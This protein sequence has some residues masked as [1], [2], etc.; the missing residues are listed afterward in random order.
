MKPLKHIFRRLALT[1]MFT[2]V[3]LVTLA[4]G[5][6]ANTAIFS[7]LN[8]VLIKP[9]PYPES[10]ALVGVWHAAPGIAS[11][12]GKKLECSPTM[13]FTYHEQNRAFQE[14]GLWSGG[15]ASV[16]GIDEPEQVEALFVT[17]GVLQALGVQPSL[18]RWFS[19][20]DDTPG[21]PETV[22]LTHGYWQRRFGGDASVIGRTLTI[23]FQ[24]RKVIGVMPQGFRSLNPNAELILPERFDRSKVFLGNFSYEGVARLKPGVTL[25]QANADIARMLQIWLESWPTPPG[26]DR[27]LF[28]NARLGPN[29]QLLKQDVVGDIGTV[30][31]VLMGTIGFVLLIAC[32]NVANLMLVRA[33][34]RQQEL[35]IRAALGAG[36][37]RIAREM[38]L[39]S[40]TLGVIGGVV[41]VALAYIGLRVL[42]AIGPATLPRLSEIEIDPLVLLFTLAVS[43]LAGVLFGLIPVLKYAGPHLA[44]ALRG[45]G[46][47]L[48]HSR[49]RHRARNTLVV[50][51]VALALMLLIGAGLMIRTFQALRST[52]P[53]FARPD[54][55]QMLRISI[56][57]TQV[58]E[59]ERV[60]RIQNEML[61]KLAVIPGARSVAFSSGAPLEGF[62]SNDVVFAEDKQYAVG[63]IPPI[64][65]FRF[66]SPGFFQTTG[67]ALIAGRDFTWT[68]LYEKRHV[69]IVSENMAREMWGDSRSA[70]G[71]RIR[72]GMRDPWREIVGV[73]ADVYDE[74]VQQSAPAFVY[75][76]LMMDT[77]WA[78][79][80]HVTRGGVFLIRS[81]LAATESFLAEAKKAIWA[82]NSNQPVFLVRTLKDVYDRSM[83]R[84]S[85]TLV[86][87][88]IASGMALVLSVVG[89]YGVIAYAVSQ[90]TREIGIRMALGAQPRGLKRMFVRHGLLLAGVGAALGMTA[91]VGVTRLM[92][93]L[94]FRITA[95]DPTTYAAVSVVLVTA[96]GVASYVP[97]RRAT[98]VDPG[99]AL[100][101]E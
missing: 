22:I 3:A 49:E 44:N 38:L 56:P 69:A 17:Y 30:L 50:M 35:A 42:V 46:R 62:N 26:F 45:S 21:T 76:P 88:V 74:G 20:E 34:G 54:E 93:S 31:W 66:V 39:E 64:R 40:I 11:L 53:G 13:Y 51:Q 59:P 16:T 8:G 86:M 72:E 80:V 95:V 60:M 10:D 94:L 4:L 5:I 15:G 91:A 81:N 85:F 90:R 52:E 47:T 27:A 83:A 98:R 25:Q 84:T 99:E 61:D 79:P 7:V 1:P 71:K 78:D 55:V 43:L 87:L 33:E 96:A 14:F 89:I 19:Q 75:W 41:G 37:G 67:T 36:W 65:R 57:E 6:G 73:A 23:N 9:L 100:R 32:A 12:Q 18:G 63:Q 58:S 82:V 77:F 2:T 29:L 68:D 70:L 97:A 101:I 28:L 92:S 48:S 24:P